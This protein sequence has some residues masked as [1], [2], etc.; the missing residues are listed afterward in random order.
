MAKGE[1]VM[2]NPQPAKLSYFFSKGYSDI[3]N[4]VKGAW[5]NNWGTIKWYWQKLVA[6]I[7]SDSKFERWFVMIIWA[8]GIASVLAVGSAITAIFTILSVVI[9][10]IIMGVIYLC[11]SIL[12]L[13]EL[14]YLKT[15]KV[16]SV[17]TFCKEEFLLPTF[18]CTTCGALHTDL[19]PSKYGILKRECNCGT[20]LPTSFMNGRNAL[21]AIC[22]NP[23]CAHPMFG[24]GSK[25]ICIPVVGGRNTGKTA[26]ITAFSV[27]FIQ[28]V[29]P[30]LG[31]TKESYNDEKEAIFDTMLEDYARGETTATT[32]E[33]DPNKPS[34][35]SYSFLVSGD[36]LDPSRLLHIYDIAGEVFTDHLENEVQQQYDYSHGIVLIIDPLSITDFATTAWDSLTE[37]DKKSASEVDVLYIMDSFLEKLQQATGLS[38]EETSKVPLAVVIS[39]ADCANLSDM[40]GDSAVQA[41]ES[42]PAYAD[43]QTTD[44]MDDLCRRFLRDNGMEAFVH[45]IQLKFRKNRFFAC[46]S[47][48]HERGSGEYEPWGVLRVMQ[49]LITSTDPSFA[50]IW[51]TEVFSRTPQGVK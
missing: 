23:E 48:G 6:A 20:K 27:D 11:F 8:C 19:R 21:P 22:S 31:F 2:D 13:V 38:D 32:R 50:K 3:V 41:L 49:W 25:P 14:I 4:V 16:F 24:T 7:N 44:I 33:T 18:I 17:C 40:I 35:I 36:A 47:I 42:D 30:R 37:I 34:S 26:F 15:N 12:W 43:W 28:N 5:I 1:K 10:A 29:M 45:A 51:D 9:L 39:K 46:S